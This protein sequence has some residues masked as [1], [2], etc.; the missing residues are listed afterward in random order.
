MIGGADFDGSAT[1]LRILLAAGALGLVNG[2]FGFAL[3]AKER[4]VAALWLNVTGPR[5]QRGA[6][7]RA[8]ASLTA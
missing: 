7:P 5:V 4:Q 6:E 2:V 3:I 1:P 8:G